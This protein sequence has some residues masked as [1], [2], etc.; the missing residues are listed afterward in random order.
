MNRYLMNP[1]F[2]SNQTIASLQMHRYSGILWRG[3]SHRDL[4]H[5]ITDHNINNPLS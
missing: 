2:K 3:G 4:A 1:I 5:G